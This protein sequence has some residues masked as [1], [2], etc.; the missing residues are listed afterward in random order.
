MLSI[1]VTPSNN[2]A[3]SQIYEQFASFNNL[4]KFVYLMFSPSMYLYTART[5]H[6]ILSDR[7]M[8]LTTHSDDLGKIV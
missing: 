4:Q 3:A 2:Y 5:C 1:L 7:R 6:N 8:I